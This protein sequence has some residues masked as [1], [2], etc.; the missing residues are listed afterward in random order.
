M[1]PN[2]SNKPEPLERVQ[3]NV[4]QFEN[5]STEEYLNEIVKSLNDEQ[6]HRCISHDLKL[7]LFNTIKETLVKTTEFQRMIGLFYKFQ[8]SK[9]AISDLISLTGQAFTP[10]R[11][12]EW[13]SWISALEYY[14]QH[15]NLMAQVCLF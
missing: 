5:D 4:E 2:I 1:K 14:H 15:H 6:C 10:I 3:L 8:K 9:S 11:S 12:S 7:V 13:S